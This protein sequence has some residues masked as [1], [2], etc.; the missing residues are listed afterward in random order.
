MKK[1]YW[2]E[3]ENDYLRE[4]YEHSRASAKAC[5]TALGLG[6]HS[7]RAQI[8]SLHLTYSYY[9]PLPTFDYS[10]LR[11]LRFWGERCPVCRGTVVVCNSGRQVCRSCDSTWDL[12]G[13]PLCTEDNKPLYVGIGARV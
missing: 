12:H 5:A 10:K 2:T 1:H 7:V 13:N 3:E 6:F 11:P 8:Q 9:E 4:H